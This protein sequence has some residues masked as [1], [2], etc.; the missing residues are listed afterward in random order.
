MGPKVYEIWGPLFFGSITAFNQKFD[1]KN[2]PDAVE[3]DFVES[4][5]SDHS[6]IEAIFN[7]VNKYNSAGKTIKLK[8][9]SQDCKILLCKSSPICSRRSLLRRLM[10]HVI[11]W[12]KIQKHLPKGFQSIRYKLFR[13]N[14]SR[15]HFFI[16]ALVVNDFTYN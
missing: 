5:I 12:P 3:I 14:R 1:I 11:I 6:A 7:L 10:I 8:H 4:R 16:I 2:D 15:Y 13:V 9:L